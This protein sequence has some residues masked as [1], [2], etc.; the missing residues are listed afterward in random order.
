[1]C[2]INLINHLDIGGHGAVN[3]IANKQQLTRYCTAQLPFGAHARP[4]TQ[5]SSEQSAWRSGR[6][7]CAL[8]RRRRI[9][10]SISER[11]KHFIEAYRHTRNAY[12][13]H[14]DT[15][16]NKVEIILSGDARARACV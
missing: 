5:S 4:E 14:N 6:E 12:T 9:K 10:A 3:A 16:G 8:G 15:H 1:V 13:I 2:Q 7:E 11:R